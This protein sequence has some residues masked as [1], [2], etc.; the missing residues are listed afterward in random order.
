MLTAISTARPMK[1]PECGDNGASKHFSKQTGLQ[2]IPAAVSQMSASMRK[3]EEYLQYGV[4]V[5]CRKP[6]GD[7]ESIG[8]IRT[9]RGRC[10]EE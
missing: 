9:E 2:T 1:C 5:T 6:E 8:I 3:H 7:F 4:A 10:Q